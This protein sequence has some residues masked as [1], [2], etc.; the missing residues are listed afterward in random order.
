MPG[1][2]ITAL[3]LA[4]AVMIA[5]VLTAFFAARRCSAGWRVWLLYAIERVYVRLLVDW[6]ANGPCPFPREGPAIIVGNHTSFVDPVLLWHNHNDDW[7]SGE[8]GVIGFMVAKEYVQR[9][10]LIGWIC[11]AM[12]SIPVRRTGRDMEAVRMALARLKAGKWLGIYPEGRLNHNPE[13]GLLPANSGVA[14]L[15]LK[16]Q[17]PVYPVWVHGAPRG[18]TV[19][20]TFLSR[21]TVRVTYGEP[22]RLHEQFSANGRLTTEVLD[23]AT[24]C[25]M[26]TLESL[27]RD[28]WFENQPAPTLQARRASE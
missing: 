27:Q 8:V 23:A 26:S 6:K 2:W 20:R 12:E 13:D 1:P 10:G 17:V 28:R 3:T 15:A 5:A 25:I 7:P 9:R 19:I 24:A 14:Y 16:S 21:S 18:T 4:A 22:I 11:R